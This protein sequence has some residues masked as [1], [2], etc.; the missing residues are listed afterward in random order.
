MAC[1]LTGPSLILLFL[2]SFVCLMNF[3][4][5]KKKKKKNIVGLTNMSLLS[6]VILKILKKGGGRRSW[7]CLRCSI[8]L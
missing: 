8:V 6:P 7:Y 2:L 4:S 5:T 1:M 3:L